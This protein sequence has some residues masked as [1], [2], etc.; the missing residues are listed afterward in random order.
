M[1]KSPASSLLEKLSISGCNYVTDVMSST[2][3]FHVNSPHSL[4]QAAG[5]LK[6]SF[7]KTSQQIFYRGQNQIYKTFSPTLVRG[8]KSQKPQS[9]RITALRNACSEITKAN[10]IFDGVPFEA[11]EA[12]L[13]HYG[14]KTSWLD[15]VDNVWISL[16]FAC[17]TA[18]AA[19]PLGQYLHF[20]RR[21]PYSDRNPYAY[22]IL[23]AADMQLS[24]PYVPGLFKGRDTEL[25]D[26]RVA[27]PSIFLRPHAQHGVLFRMRGTGPRR[28]VDYNPQIKG[29]IRIDLRNA[30]EWMGSGKLVG[31]QTLFPPAHYDHGYALLLN[32]SFKGSKLVGAI[33]QIGT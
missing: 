19:G 30:I 26:L 4:A 29:V 9:D 5:Y 20:E 21:D 1:S 13:Q 6:Y 25:I 32:T 18:H 15:L 8:I 33:H 16:W 7:G 24:D 10:S 3:V 14:L 22:I 23:V 28:P 31:T 11:Q 2:E 27:V 12:L 17:H